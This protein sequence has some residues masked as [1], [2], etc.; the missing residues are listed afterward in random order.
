MKTLHLA[1]PFAGLLF[2][3]LLLPSLN[4][5]T[6]APPNDLC[7]DAIPINCGQT[8]SGSTIDAANTGALFFCAGYFLS[9]T[10]GV[11]YSFAGNGQLVTASLCGS[12]FDTQIGIFAGSCGAL[13]CVTANDDVCDLQSQVSFFSLEGVTYFIYVTGYEPGDEGDFT[14]SLTCE[15]ATTPPNDFCADAITIA[16][17]QT[18]TGYT[19]LATFTDAPEMCDGYELNTGPGVWYQF[20]GMGQNTTA[21]LCG[22]VFDT[23][24]GIFS[25][26]CENLTCISANDDECALQSEAT[27]FAELGETYFIYVTGFLEEAGAYTLA[28]ECDVQALSV[29]PE[30]H[31]FPAEGGSAAISVS[32]N[33]Q[34]TAVEQVD[35]LA[36]E[37][38]A[39][40]G[41]GAFTIVCDPNPES[42]LRSANVV[43]NGQGLAAI[44]TVTQD[45]V[46]SAGNQLPTISQFQLYPNPNRGEFQVEARLSAP[47]TGRLTVYDALG[48]PVWSQM[49]EWQ[50]GERSIDV[51]L[52]MPAPG[53]YWFAIQDGSAIR[54]MGFVVA[55]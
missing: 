6:L 37:N 9:E 19:I 15:N 12:D 44:V 13:E 52:P 1:R 35:W 4:A 50:A 29:H 55:L 17:G 23:Q 11:W 43:V 24:I 33:V 18:M 53:F 22:S 49:A 39:G 36:L 10:G 47:F 21:S 34:W 14:L 38:A 26:T 27:F 20:T 48:R 40:S 41:N 25:G 5:S 51:V 30:A 8:L 16:C 2:T 32:G 46:S 45:G 42:T 28:L 7:A 3:F 54:R 31:S